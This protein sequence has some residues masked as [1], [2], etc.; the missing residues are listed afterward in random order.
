MTIKEIAEVAGCDYHHANR[1]CNKLF[2]KG[3]QG[4]KRVLNENQSIELMKS[5]KKKNFVTPLQNAKEPLQN[6]QQE[7]LTSH[8]NSKDIELISAI[9]SQTVAATMMQLDKRLQTVENRID[10]NQALLPPAIS[11]RDRL[12]QM[13]NKYAALTETPHSAVYNLLY[14]DYY[15]RYNTNIKQRA[16]NEGMSVLDYAEQNGH[17]A[18]LIACMVALGE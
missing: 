9:V 6:E 14:N 16:K 15:Y 4:K 3:A 10:K 11:D 17:I 5:L 12:R 1:E 13:I 7:G 8:L 2:G 18:E